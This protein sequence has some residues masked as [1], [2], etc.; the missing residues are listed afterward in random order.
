[1]S[2]LRGWG[3]STVALSQILERTTYV[4]EVYQGDEKYSQGSA[5]C[6]HPRGFLVTAAHVVTGRFPIREEDWQDPNVKIL[7]RISHGEFLHYS[8]VFCGITI[9]FPGPMKDPLQIDLAVL[10]PAKPRSGVE[11]LTVAAERWPRVGTWVL[12]AGF[13]DELEAPLLWTKAVNQDYPQIKDDPEIERKIELVNQQ[14]MIKSGMIGNVSNLSIDPDGS[15]KKML[16]V[17][18]YYVDNVMHSG[19][20][21]GPVIDERGAVIGTISKRA[22]TVVPFPELETPNKEVP[23]GSALAISTFTAIDWLNDWALNDT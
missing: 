19:S 8:P 5:Y 2:L 7:A 11:H 12:M 15:A 14:L 20:S 10:R 13:P 6:V 22:V 1:M 23:S 17:A 18:A 9:N 4:L 16:Q 21:G 3:V